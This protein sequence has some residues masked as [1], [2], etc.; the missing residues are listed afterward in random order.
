MIVTKL[1]GCVLEILTHRECKTFYDYCII[2]EKQ[3][4]YLFFTTQLF[5]FSK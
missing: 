4:M 1:G 2:K 3:Y 5:I